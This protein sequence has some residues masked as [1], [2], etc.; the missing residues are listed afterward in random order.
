MPSQLRLKDTVDSQVIADKDAKQK[1]QAASRDKSRY[2]G[3][4]KKVQAAIEDLDSQIGHLKDEIGDLCNSYQSLSLSGSFAGQIAKSV[5][6]FELNLE[7]LQTNGADPQTIR[8]MEKSIETMR[9]KQDLV[10]EAAAAMRSKVCV[11]QTRPA[12]ERNLDAVAIA[13]LAS[14]IR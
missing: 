9:Q 2:Q 4:L 8:M 13:V 6:L 7:A 14:W 12:P 11:I 5:R 1:F 3:A 10:N